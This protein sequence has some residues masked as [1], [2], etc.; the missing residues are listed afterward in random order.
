MKVSIKYINGC[1]MSNKDKSLIKD[2]I[3]FLNK[4]HPLKND[5]TILFTGKRFGGMSTGSRTNE[6]YFK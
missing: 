3:K 4:E 1:D 2:F 6:N 5:V